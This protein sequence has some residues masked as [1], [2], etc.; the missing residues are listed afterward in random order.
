MP[1]GFSAS[2]VGAATPSTRRLASHSTVALARSLADIEI[3][4]GSDL[5]VHALL[6]AIM[7]MRVLWNA[8]KSNGFLSVDCVRYL[9]SMPSCPWP[10]ASAN[11]RPRAI[12]ASTSGYALSL[13]RDTSTIAA[14]ISL[15]ANSRALARLYAGP[16]T[17][18]PSSDSQSSSIAV[19][20]GSSST[21]KIFAIP[22]PVVGLRNVSQSTCRT[23]RKALQTREVHRLLGACYR[24]QCGSLALRRETGSRVSLPDVPK[25][26]FAAFTNNR[27]A[28]ARTAELRQ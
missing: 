19:I 27:K 15:L 18:C 12:K 1:I 23:R 3:R 11:G 2:F 16:T 7:S 5:H 21:I 14:S 17:S 26:E 25:G 28:A 10:V 9:G 20:N 6:R 22:T 13:P 4:C 24:R 8:A